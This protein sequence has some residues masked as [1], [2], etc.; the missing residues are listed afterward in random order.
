MNGS[1]CLLARLGVLALALTCAGLLSSC[2]CGFKLLNRLGNTPTI[3]F[4]ADPKANNTSAVAVDVVL[5]YD[6]ALREELRAQTAATWFA[7]RDQRRKDNPDATR[8]YQD[9]RLELVPGQDTTLTIPRLR[10]ARDGIVFAGYSTPGQHRESFVP[11]LGL[12]VALGEENF[13]VEV[14]PPAR[15]SSKNP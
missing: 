3:T 2:T 14:A 8:S 15:R 13:E 4:V 1:R 9:F 12:Q 7:S 6:E 11:G 5:V 10:C